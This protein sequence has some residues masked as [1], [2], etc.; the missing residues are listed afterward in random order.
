MSDTGAVHNLVI[1]RGIKWTWHSMQTRVLLEL[2]VIIKFGFFE[3]STRTSSNHSKCHHRRFGLRNLLGT[4]SSKFGA[5]YTCQ[6]VTE[7]ILPCNMTESEPQQV[8]IPKAL[9]T[10]L[11]NVG[12]GEK[13]W[14]LCT[15]SIYNMVKQSIPTIKG[16][17]KF[18]DKALATIAALTKHLDDMTGAKIVVIDHDQAVELLNKLNKFI[19]DQLCFFDDGLD[20]LRGFLTDALRDLIASIVKQKELASSKLAMITRKAGEVNDATVSIVRSRF[21]QAIDIIKSL[22]ATVKSHYPETYATTSDFLEKSYQRANDQVSA[23]KESSA[24]IVK[25]ADAQLHTA[26]VYLLRTAQP[27]VH[28]A[29]NRSSPYLVT[30]VEVSQLYV[31][32]ARPYIDPIVVPL[33]ERAQE[34]NQALQHHKMVG[35]YVVRAYETA[36]KTLED[37]KVYCLSDDFTSVPSGTSAE[38]EGVPQEDVKIAEP[39]KSERE[40]KRKMKHVVPAAPAPSP[41]DADADVAAGASNR[42]SAPVEAM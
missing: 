38:A 34:M 20:Y 9:A 16:Q 30:A 35:P 18:F 40:A 12:H 3:D 25:K 23:A 8:E 33:V 28:T 19:T 42:D 22:F 4:P 37:V 26:S 21:E 39:S 27:Y 11:D 6:V 24:E 7:A 17:D 10:V 5:E 15:L 32:Q 29:V 31:V 13:P 41:T 1:I 2:I 36:S 14:Y